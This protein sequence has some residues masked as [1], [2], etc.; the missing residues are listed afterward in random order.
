[1]KVSPESGGGGGRISEKSPS[2]AITVVPA[3]KPVPPPKDPTPSPA[4]DAPVSQAPE[5]EEEPERGSIPIIRDFAPAAPAQPR[6][7]VAS[8]L[9]QESQINRTS[10][11]QTHA[12]ER[13]EAILKALE[14]VGS[15]SRGLYVPE[16]GHVGVATQW[17]MV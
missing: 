4:Q 7:Q 5:K 1:M 10:D 2:P 9:S 12:R 6:A 8:S 13:R 16:R 17:R 11:P 15:V 14:I 3:R